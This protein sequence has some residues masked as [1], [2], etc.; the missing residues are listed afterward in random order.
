MNVTGKTSIT[1]R[2]GPRELLSYKENI[3]TLVVH[4]YFKRHAL[5]TGYWKSLLLVSIKVIEFQRI[6]QAVT[7][8]L[9]LFNVYTFSS[10]RKFIKRIEEVLTCLSLLK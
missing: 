3:K 1:E 4:Y 9:H 7:S 10:M 6:I 8:F 2:L 5:Y